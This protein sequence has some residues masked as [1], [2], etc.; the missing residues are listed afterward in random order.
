LFLLFRKICRLLIDKKPA[1]DLVQPDTRGRSVLHWL[2]AYGGHHIDV[3]WTEDRLFNVQPP[4]LTLERMFDNSGHSPLHIAAEKDNP[5]AITSI[6]LRF[7]GATTVLDKRKRS[8]LHIAAYYGTVG[9][10]KA[11]LDGG[12]DVNAVDQRLRTPLIEASRMGKYAVLLMLINQGADVEARD[13]FNLRG[14]E[15]AA[16]L[17]SQVRFVTGKTERSDQTLLWRRN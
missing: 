4:I 12:W 2:S 3:L 16:Q 15:Y 17:G 6:L 8:P 9:A 7:P 10:L 13:Q 11:L 5:A 1:N 14:V